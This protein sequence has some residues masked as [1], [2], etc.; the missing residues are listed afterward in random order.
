[1]AG[2]QTVVLSLGISHLL[3]NA[4]LMTLGHLFRKESF[5][6]VALTLFFLS[7]KSFPMII[8]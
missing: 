5:A 4:D 1:M 6:E 3:L 7:P 8:P 2:A